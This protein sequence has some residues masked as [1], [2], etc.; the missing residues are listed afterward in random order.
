MTT[1]VYVACAESRDIAVLRLDPAT[2]ALTPLQRVDTGGAVMPLALSPDRRFLY[3]SIRSGPFDVVSFAIDPGSGRLRAIG[4]SRLP[5]SSCWIS[6]DPSGRWLLSASYDG[7]AIA[8]GPIDGSGV[9]QTASQTAA[10]GPNAHSL[11]ADPHNRFLFASC[12]GGGVLL[13]YRFDATSGRFTPDEDSTWRGHAGAG[14]RHFAFHPQRSLVYLLNELDASIDVLGYD[15]DRGRLTSLQTIDSLPVGFTGKP[16]AADIHLT[17]DGRFVYSSERTSNT[18]AGFAVDAATGRLSLV[19]HTATEAQPRGFAIDPSGR[20][21]VAAG[22]LSAG[23]GVHAID[24]VT[25][26]LQP[27]VRQGTGGDPNW[28]EIVELSVPWGR[29]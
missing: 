16:W 19:G 21:L 13:G 28:V 17:P 26:H 6:T 3:A 10:T 29:Y 9:A 27:P 18:L 2:G 15:A 5:H 14:P 23:V 12:L 7:S 20:W 24:T 25:G 4:R 8:V 1:I 22:Q 11:Q